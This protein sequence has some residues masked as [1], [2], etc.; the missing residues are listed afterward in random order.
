ML[1]VSSFEASTSSWTITSRTRVLRIPNQRRR[2]K[3]ERL[4]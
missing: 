4:T 3:H 2:G 1:I